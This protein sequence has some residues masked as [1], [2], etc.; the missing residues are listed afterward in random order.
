M[1]AP[2][3]SHAHGGD[4]NQ[5]RGFGADRQR[6]RAGCARQREIT[7]P[8]AGIE[9][10]RRQECGQHELDIVMIERAGPEPHH[11]EQ[12]HE[13]QRQRHRRCRAT[14]KPEAGQ[15]HAGKQRRQKQQRP[16]QRGDDFRHRRRQKQAEKGDQRRNRQ[17]DDARPVHQRAAGGAEPIL[18]QVEPALTRKPIAHLDQTHGIIRIGADII[19]IMGEMNAQLGE[20][21]RQ[22]K[23]RD[24]QQ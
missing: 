20:D 8:G 16:D 24:K 12:E 2:E 17:V 1:D 14:A 5:R 18:V 15:A 21:R 4:R 22:R 10:H 11:G 6:D 7:K 23:Q 13:G 9:Q 19:D 3:H